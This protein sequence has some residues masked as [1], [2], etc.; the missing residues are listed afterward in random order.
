[1]PIGS[2]NPEARTASRSLG[3]G[4]LLD[5]GIYSLT[6]ASLIFDKA[7]G[8]QAD[9]APSLIAAMTFYNKSDPSSRVDE[10]S[11]V[12]L[13]Y[14]DLKAQAICTAS[15]LYKSR[16]EFARIE[17]SKGSIA[18]GG[19]AASKPGFL[20][21][22]KAGQEEE[23]INFD[24]PG[25]GFYYEADAVAEDIRAGRQENAVCSWKDTLTIMER[26]D[27]ARSICGLTY[28]QDEQ[29]V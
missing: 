25:W 15:L 12:V 27:A 2:A 14:S 22:R 3:A 17:G 7:P 5:I 21:V 9:V 10:Q 29:V 4:A 8:R 19:P 11:T 13:N 18:V 16:E 6:W 28:P 24:I 26:L 23:R 1:M 20:V